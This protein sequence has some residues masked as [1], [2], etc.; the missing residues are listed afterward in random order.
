MKA[1]RAVS[2]QVTVMRWEEAELELSVPAETASALGIKLREAGFEVRVASL[3]ARATAYKKG[4]RSGD[5]VRSINGICPLNAAHAKEILGR[6]S[7]H[8][9]THK[10]V[11]K[12]PGLRELSQVPAMIFL[13]CLFAYCVY[14]YGPSFFVHK[15]TDAGDREL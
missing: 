12:R 9:N 15:R 4:L 13:T 14:A 6:R 2:S 5:R 10:L 3:S 11:L 8:G 7:I 1:F